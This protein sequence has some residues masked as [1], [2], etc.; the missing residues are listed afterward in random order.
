[1]LLCD[2]R[3]FHRDY[4]PNSYTVPV[5]RRRVWL[6]IFCSLSFI[7]HNPDICL[8]LFA[9]NDVSCKFFRVSSFSFSVFLLFF[10]LSFLPNVS[11]WLLRF[12]Y[13]RLQ[14]LQVLAEQHIFVSDSF[15]RVAFLHSL[16]S[17]ILNY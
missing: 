9:I 16:C 3:I 7:A 5:L 2:I 10:F 13:C 6:D 17:L 11:K 15:L 14:A 12:M 4:I 1:M 8:S